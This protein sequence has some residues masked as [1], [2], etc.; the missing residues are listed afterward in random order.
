MTYPLN[1]INKFGGSKAMSEKTGFPT[2]TI[3]SWRARCAI[4]DEHKPTIL[5]A[6]LEN[7][8]ALGPADFFPH[9]D[10]ECPTADR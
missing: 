5:K 3:N 1:I 4:H 10:D 2:A 7:G 8:I 9:T 6:A